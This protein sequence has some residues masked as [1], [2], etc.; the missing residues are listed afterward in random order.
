M[1]PR[2]STNSTGRRRTTR[3]TTRKTT[4]AKPAAT[5]QSHAAARPADPAKH[6]KWLGIS[7]IAVGGVLGVYIVVTLIAHLTTSVNNVIRVLTTV[8][9]SPVATTKI[10]GYFWWM[11]LAV[12]IILA[13]VLSVVYAVRE[14]LRG[15]AGSR[16]FIVAAVVFLAAFIGSFFAPNLSE[17]TVGYHAYAERYNSLAKFQDQRTKLSSGQVDPSTNLPASQ[18]QAQALQQLVLAD[19]IRQEARKHG[20]KVSNKEVN[21]TYKQYADRNQGEDNLRKQLKDFLGWTPAQFKKEIQVKLLEDKLNTKLAQDDKLNADQKKK[22]E[23]L[24]TQV[25]SGADFAEVAKQSDDPTG[26]TGGDQGFVKKGEV[27]PALESAI[28]SKNVGEITD[29]TKTSRGYVIAKVT[30]KKDDT[31][32][33][34]LILVTTKSL[35]QVLVEDLKGTKVSVLL[36]DLKWNSSNGSIVPTK[37]TPTPASAASDSPAPITGDTAAPAASTAPAPAAQ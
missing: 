24:L 34:S 31:L 14:L 7:T 20:V 30:D 6:A 21:D 26:Q 5:T 15:R 8:F 12:V 27:E 4:A 2:K 22:A 29:V 9:N 23:D 25:K 13:L 10:P 18:L 28:F 19:I 32:K 16:G 35:Q 11:V 1:P 33:F 17:S 3:T 36:R 37:T